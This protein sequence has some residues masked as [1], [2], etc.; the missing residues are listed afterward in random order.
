MEY[1][2]S[3]TLMEL[4]KTNQMKENVEYVKFYGAIMFL[5]LDYFQSKGYLHRD[6]KPSNLMI[7]SDGYLK[8]IDFG[9][10]KN[11]SH[12]TKDFTLTVIGTPTFMAPEMINGKL[13]SFSCDYWS[14]GVC[15]YN[16]YY[17]K[18][19]FGENHSDMME[20]YE[21]IIKKEVPFSFGQGNFELNSLLTNLLCKKPEERYKTLEE[22]KGHNFFKGFQWS[23]LL[24]KKIKAPF[25]PQKEGCPMNEGYCTNTNT[26]FLS[27]LEFEKYSRDCLSSTKRSKTG[28]KRKP[29]EDGDVMKRFF[30]NN[31]ILKVDFQ[32]G[33][34][35][36]GEL[37]N[38]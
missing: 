31:Y 34:S 23:E 3:K 4:M 21:S 35:K 28:N 37:E 5:V 8:F 1:V 22:I 30:S 14:V 32:R 13:Y 19:P 20:V 38:F 17:G 27:F 10:A 11:I 9:T 24:R 25:V 26:P 2:G 7:D 6:I 18:N 29:I 16:I 33:M 36:G 12:E 15:L